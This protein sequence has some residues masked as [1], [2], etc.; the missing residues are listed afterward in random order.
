MI[1]IKRLQNFI[2]FDYLNFILF[3]KKF[4]LKFDI[5]KEIFKIQYSNIKN[6][7]LF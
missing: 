3:D 4:Q 7:I 6:P 1:L 2:S 5:T